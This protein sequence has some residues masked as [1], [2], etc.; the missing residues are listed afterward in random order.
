MRLNEWSKTIK[1]KYEANPALVKILSYIALLLFAFIFIFSVISV[2]NPRYSVNDDIAILSDIK[3]GFTASFIC[4]SFGGFLSFLYN[5]VS[6]SIPWY[7]V[8]MYISLGISLFA[9][10]NI[11]LNFRRKK[12]IETIIISVLIL[13]SYIRFIQIVGYNEVSVIAGGVAVLGIFS[14]FYREKVNWHSALGYGLLLAISY[15]CRVDTLE[16]ILIF[17]FPIVI[18]KIRKYWK[19]VIIFALPC[20]LLIAFD[21]TLNHAHYMTPEQ[22]YFDATIPYYH[23]IMD[24]SVKLLNQENTALFKDSV[25]SKNDFYMI[26]NWLFADENKYNLDTMNQFLENPHIIKLSNL[27][28]ASLISESIKSFKYMMVY[29]SKWIFAIILE[30]ILLIFYCKKKQVFLPFLLFLYIIAGSILI[31]LIFHY[32][33]RVGFPIFFIIMC[34]LFI[35]LLN[36]DF[37]FGNKWSKLRVMLLVIISVIFIYGQIALAVSNDKANKYNRDNMY[38]VIEQLDSLGTDAVFLS[39]PLFL[40]IYV[41]ANPLKEYQEEPLMIPTGWS[42]FS[43]RFYAIINK[44]GLKH[45]SDVFPYFANSKNS[46]VICGE[47]MKEPI[48]IFI[49]ENYGIETELKLV[50]T[51]PQ[52]LKRSWNFNIYK[53]EK[54]QINPITNPE[55]Q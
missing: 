12:L 16:L 8:F 45:G 9:L 19:Y 51:L 13:L 30:F 36:G 43:P 38:R 5:D 35:I 14:A 17:M 21:V 23:A 39:H 27:G 22:T 50:N 29:Y 52:L 25:W 40:D 1:Q 6:S 48:S 55:K 28:F 54:K 42:A 3:S 31:E 2:I 37:S 7:G 53:I 49:K 15:L 10:L 47:S 41:F 46:F 24:S 26:T 20:L 44:I 18:F 33:S 11:L 32:P 4:R 34:F